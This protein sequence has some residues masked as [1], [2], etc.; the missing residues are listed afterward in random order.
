[1]GR[2]KTPLR[3]QRPVGQ[4]TDR[5]HY[6]FARSRIKFM[7]LNR[8]ETYFNGQTLQVYLARSGWVTIKGYG[9]VH[10]QVLEKL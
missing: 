4:E 9:R 8:G 10:P 6:K 3:R 1:M 5:A 7:S 2:L